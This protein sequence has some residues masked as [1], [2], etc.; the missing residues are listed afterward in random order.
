MQKERELRSD[1]AGAAGRGLGAERHLDRDAELFTIRTGSRTTSRITG[2]CIRIRRQGPLRQR[3]P[4]AALGPDQFYL[5]ALKIEADFGAF[6]TD[7]QH[8]VLPPQERHRLRRHACTTSASTRHFLASELIRVHRALCM[9]DSNRRAPARRASTNYRSPASVDNGQQNFTQEIRLQSNDP[10]AQAACGP[11]ACSSATTASTTWSRFTI[12]MSKQ[13]PQAVYAG[14]H[15]TDIFTDVNGNSSGPVTTR[16]I[17]NDSYFLQTNAK[18][19]QL[20]VS[21]KAPTASRIS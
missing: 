19:Q 4:D 14:T 10:A 15:Y 16:A 2:R 1:H 7:F 20:A 13:F 8:L 17:P 3:Q 6:A 9:L 21:A 18:D 12:R 5:P 11:P